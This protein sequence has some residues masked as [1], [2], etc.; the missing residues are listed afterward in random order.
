[1]AAMT[2]RTAKATA[3]EQHKTQPRIGVAGPS[4]TCLLVRTSATWRATGVQFAASL[5]RSY[6]DQPVTKVSAS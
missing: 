1:M 4:G 3:D 6:L 2:D 5:V